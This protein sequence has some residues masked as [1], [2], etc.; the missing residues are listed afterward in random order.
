MDENGKWSLSPAYDMT[1]I[2]NTGGFLPESM[3]C[4]TMQGKLFGHTLEDA[5]TLAKENGIRKANAIINEVADAIKSFRAYAEKHDVE[6]KWISAIET[7]LTKHLNEW[8]FS[9][10]H[11]PRFDFETDGKRFEN[12][13]IEQAYKGNYTTRNFTNCF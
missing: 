12:V 13:H 8:G 6:E 9:T 10:D 2:F 7:C 5:M 11:P 3:H 4:L 1:Y